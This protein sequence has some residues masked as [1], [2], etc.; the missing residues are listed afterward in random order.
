MR[1]PR[2]MRIIGTILL[3]AV[4]WG[5]CDYGLAETYTLQPDEHGFILKAPD[6]KTVFRYMTKKPAVTNLTANSVCCLYPLNA[7]SGERAVDFAP[8][9]HRHHRG[10][11]LAWHAT[12][13]AKPADF[14]GWGSMAPTE[15]RV[16]TNRS[17]E[18]AEAD[19]DHAVLKVGNDWMVEENP[20]IREA[21]TIT[22]CRQKGVN[23]V[24]IEFKLTSTEE[25]TLKQTAFG[26]FCVKGRKEGEAYYTDPGGKVVLPKPHHLKPQTDWPAAAWYD[27]TID[28]ENGGT[29]GIT[30]I[31][32]PKNPPS[33]WHNLM[34]IAM[35]NPC[36]VAPGPVVLK[37][38]KPL[39]LRY[40]LVVHDGPPP[41]AVIKELSDQWRGE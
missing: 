13:G 2:R 4:A 31:D 32:H 40:R 27:Y 11:F 18:L 17:V 30:V 26:G 20:V 15:N 7:P 35:I 23:V 12:E 19:G 14:W 16:I 37:E 33:T 39:V 34:P 9:D 22:A 28:L 8:G 10:V 3:L 29:V 38:G 25:V 6:G 36:I 1:S 41:V 21:T 5:T 24:D